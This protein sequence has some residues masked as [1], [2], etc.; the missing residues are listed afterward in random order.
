ME[1][2]VEEVVV[3]DDP[4]AVTEVETEQEAQAEVQA[5][6]QDKAED[7]AKAEM[8]HLDPTDR[9]DTAGRT[10]TACIIARRAVTKRKA[11]WMS[12]PSPT[13]LAATSTIALGSDIWGHQLA[14]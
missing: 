14:S 7:A 12:Q 13:C 5:E 3:A 1:A 8:V 2:E 6:V 10:A 9:Q 11:I 4:D